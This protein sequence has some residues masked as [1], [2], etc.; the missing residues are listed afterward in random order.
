MMLQQLILSVVSW[1]KTSDS[2]SELPLFRASPDLLHLHCSLL[3]YDQVPTWI[4]LAACLAVAKRNHWRPR[5]R[6]LLSFVRKDLPS[7]RVGENQGQIKLVPISVGE[8]FI[9]SKLSK[10][11]QDSSINTC[12]SPTIKPSVNGSPWVPAQILKKF[13]TNLYDWGITASGGRKI[14]ALRAARQHAYKKWFLERYNS[15]RHVAPQ[16]IVVNKNPGSAPVLE[17]LTIK[18]DL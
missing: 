16:S 4:R 8:V 15:L 2:A 9:W 11:L 14:A 1:H 12:W 5:T 6:S 10:Q 18:Y 7:R 17:F 13:C 3:F